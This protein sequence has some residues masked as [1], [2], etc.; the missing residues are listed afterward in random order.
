MNTVFFG[1]IAQFYDSLGIMVQDNNVPFVKT[2]AVINRDSLGIMTELKMPNE[3]PGYFGASSEFIPIN[4]ISHFENDVIKFDSLT[5]DTTLV[6]YI[7]GGINST[8]SNIFFTNTGIQSIASSQIYKVSLIKGA[9]TGINENTQ[10]DG[11]LMDIYPNPNTGDFKIKFELKE[12]E[13]LQL[14]IY[15]LDG[16][17]IKTKVLKNLEIGEN[18]IDVSLNDNVKSS[19][20]LIKIESPKYSQQRII[21]VED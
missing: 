4:T 10:A 14:S 6:G 5:A 12:V 9:Q 20:Y 18:I 3:M 1:G 7:Y 2:I 21:V 16:R 15:H 11:F 19:S 13:V 8:A 17:L